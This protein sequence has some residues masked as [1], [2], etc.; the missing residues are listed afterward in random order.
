MSDADH[1]QIHFR[2][3]VADL[4]R[5]LIREGVEAVLAAERAR[6]MLLSVAEAAHELRTHERTIRRWIATGAPHYR[7]SPGGNI[8]IDSEE[9]RAWSAGEKVR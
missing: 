4:P 9:L 7:H 2:V 8:L 5:N 6:P 3:T 1:D